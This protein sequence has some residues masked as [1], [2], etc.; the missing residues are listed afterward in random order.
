[1]ILC[2]H[3][4]NYCQ[5]FNKCMKKENGEIK[6]LVYMGKWWDQGWAILEFIVKIYHSKKYHGIT[7]YH[8]IWYNICSAWFLDIRI[9]QLV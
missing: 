4:K 9:Y 6:S 7:I 5:G 1:M 8:D 3:C 2:E